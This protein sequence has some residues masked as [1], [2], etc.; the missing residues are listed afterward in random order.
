MKKG[1]IFNSTSHIH[2]MCREHSDSLIFMNDYIDDT[3]YSFLKRLKQRLKRAV[4]DLVS[5][6]NLHLDKYLGARFTYHKKVYQS[7][8]IFKDKK[9]MRCP[10]CSLTFLHPMPSNAELTQ[11][12]CSSFWENKN[13][14]FQLSAGST[15]EKNR[16]SYQYEFMKPFID[17]SPQI[18]QVLEIGAGHAGISY[19]IHNLF[20]ETSISILEPDESFR[21]AHENLGM[22]KETFKDLNEI[23]KTYDLILSSHSLEHVSNIME[24]IGIAARILRPNGYFFLEVPNANEIYFKSYRTDI[25]HTY[26]FN[27]ESIQRL[28]EYFNLKVLDIGAFGPNKK[29]FLQSN[30]FSIEEKNVRKADGGNLR[31]LLQKQS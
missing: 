9:I 12:Y 20:P 15:K 4:L 23:D 5:S 2:C 8:L 11:Y 28:G 6:D 22:C 3:N 13:A 26:F 18:K 17:F 29:E 25:P 7:E 21:K 31:C 14:E 19:F 30:G 1:T 16:A 10:N 27:I 24:D